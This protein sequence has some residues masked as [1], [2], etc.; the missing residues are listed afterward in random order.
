MSMY[1]QYENPHT[2]EARLKNL[3][4]RRAAL[5]LSPETEV[6]LM[7]LDIEIHELKERI[8]FA[9]QDDEADSE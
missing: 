9:W 6:E 1:R 2:L 3:Q 5:T 7:D 8:N 4:A